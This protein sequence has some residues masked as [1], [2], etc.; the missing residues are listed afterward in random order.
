MCKA[1]KKCKIP[2][3]KI[4]LP[5]TIKDISVVKINAAQKDDKVE[6]EMH[7]HAA[8]INGEVIAEKIAGVI[9]WL[10]KNN[11]SCK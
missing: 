9:L 7:L 2:S 10:T 5:S 4:N 6:R 1:V 3:D 11:S 8:K